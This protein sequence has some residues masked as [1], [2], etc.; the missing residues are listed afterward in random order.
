MMSRYVVLMAAAIPMAFAA[1]V[2]VVEEIAAK[3]NGDIIT[4]GDLEQTRREIEQQLRQEGLSGQKLT[5]SVSQYSANA[6][7]EK[8][9]EL[10]LVQKGRT[11]D[12]KSIPRSTGGWPSSRCRARSRT[13]TSS[14]STSAS[15]PGC[16]LKTTRNA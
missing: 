16:R 8:I 9:D 12:I 15:R 1:D 14:T 7:R 11:M 3:V 13:R 2:K 6:L 4:R 5:E 10:L